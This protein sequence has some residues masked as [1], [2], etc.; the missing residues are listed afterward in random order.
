MGAVGFLQHA[1]NEQLCA[2]RTPS[3]VQIF[4]ELVQIAN[5]SDVVISKR[6]RIFP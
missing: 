2:A 5:L 1:H 6:I 3:D 4:V